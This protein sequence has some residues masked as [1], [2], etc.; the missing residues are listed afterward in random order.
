MECQYQLLVKIHYMISRYAGAL[1]EFVLKD[2]CD[3]EKGIQEKLKFVD[4]G[5]IRLTSILENDH[6]IQL[7]LQL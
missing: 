5:C 3:R 7:T 2:E 6:I 4:T 1:Q